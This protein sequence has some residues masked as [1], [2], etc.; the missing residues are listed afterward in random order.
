MIKITYKDI[1]TLIDKS[2]ASIKGYKQSQPELLEL[3]LLGAR[4]KLNNISV[5]ELELFAE[6]KEKLEEKK[7]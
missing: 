5:E 6:F 1:A 2:E 3:L 4:C 7:N